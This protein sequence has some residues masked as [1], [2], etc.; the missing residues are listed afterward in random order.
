MALACAQ[1]DWAGAKAKGNFV[2]VMAFD[3]S[4]AFDTIDPAALLKKIEATG[5]KGTP[6]KWLESYMSGR[7]QSVIW[8]GR[9]SESLNL[10]HG[11]AQGSILGPLLFLVMV[12]DL[13]KYV[14]KD[15]KNGK[16][17]SYADDS[18]LSVISKTKEGLKSD[19]E[20]MAKRM[21]EYCSKNGLI[22]NSSKTQLLV[23][24]NGD[25]KVCVGSSIITAESEICLLG[26]DYDK[27]FSTAPYLR[28]LATEANTRAAVIYRLSFSVPPHLLKLLA[29]G[30]VIGKIA[31]AAPAAIPFK[32]AH[33]DQAANLATE[34]I[35]RAINSV[36]RT[37]TK[38]RLKDMV[39]SATV[40]EKCGLRS[41]NEM[42]A[43]SAVLMAWKAKKSMNPLGSCI[44]PE[45]VNLRPVRSKNIH[46]ATQPVPGNRTLASNLI[47]KS[48]NDATELHSVDTLAAAKIVSR[49]WAS[50]LLK[51]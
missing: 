31:A 33:D 17:M 24:W 37:I 6:L 9:Q 42:V 7:S 16:L 45:K 51:S 10:T 23:S 22:I 44:F 28:G 48:W 49:K 15:F 3:L 47:A 13:P 21:I 34:K 26:I 4:A 1:A 25:F 14:T 32:I 18:T 19:L 27:N 11:V 2:G 35:N 30:L 8:N 39:S 43:S 46:K 36:A 5:V 41:L 50:N 29:N 38:T 12:A 40:R 20:S